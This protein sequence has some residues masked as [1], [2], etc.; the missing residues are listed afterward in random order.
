M[1]ESQKAELERLLA[2]SSDAAR[3]RRIELTDSMSE[4]LSVLAEEC[5]RRG[6]NSDELKNAAASFK[7]FAHQE[8]QALHE[9]R[10]N[11]AL[12]EWLAGKQYAAPS[13]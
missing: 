6:L 7:D 5:E 1:I 2:D 12:T 4:Q 3:A 11:H 9:R 13:T 8:A 10:R